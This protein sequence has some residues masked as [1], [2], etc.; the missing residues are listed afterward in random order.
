MPQRDKNQFAFLRDGFQIRFFQF[1]VAHA[2]QSGKKSREFLARAFARSGR[3][4]Q[5]GIGM[6]R[7]KPRD[8][9]AGIA[10]RTDN[11]DAQKGICHERQFNQSGV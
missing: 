4:N 3:Q 5:L 10:R 1:D 9:G 2:T 6:K 11:S 8:F 7:Q